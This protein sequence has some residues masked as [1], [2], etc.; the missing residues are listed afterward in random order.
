MYDYEFRITSVQTDQE[1][2]K[3]VVYGGNHR[4]AHNLGMILINTI[5]F[6]SISSMTVAL[7]ITYP[8]N[9]CKGIQHYFQVNTMAFSQEIPGIHAEG[10]FL[11]AIYPTTEAQQNY[12]ASLCR[13]HV[14]VEQGFVILMRSSRNPEVYFSVESAVLNEN[15]Y[16]L[17]KDNFQHHLSYLLQIQYIQYDTLRI[18]QDQAAAYVIA[19]AVLHYIGIERSDIMYNIPDVT[20]HEK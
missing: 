18:N 20:L 14:L 9:I 12:N 15:K 3:T 6:F 11:L 17:I 2:C 10:I 19:C 8:L 13:T 16:L 5:R 7:K 4:F 1:V